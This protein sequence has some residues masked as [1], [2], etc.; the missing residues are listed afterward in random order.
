LRGKNPV[1]FLS[2]PEAKFGPFCSIEAQPARKPKSNLTATKASNCKKRLEARVGIEPTYK[3]FADLS[4]TTWVPRPLLSKNVQRYLTALATAYALQRQT[5]WA[6]WAKNLADFVC[7]RSIIFTDCVSIAELRLSFLM[8][9]AVL[10][11]AHRS[12]PS[13]H[14]RCIAMAHSVLGLYSFSRFSLVQM[15][16]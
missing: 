14:D 11:H 1:R 7:H 5:I 6:T 4:L 16:K 3:G 10:T 13:V 8:P 15:N 2:A 9:E 12:I